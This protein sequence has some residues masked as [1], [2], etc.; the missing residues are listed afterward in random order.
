M[1]EAH[2]ISNNCLGCGKS[3]SRTALTELCYTFEVCPCNDYEYSG[4][5][6]GEAVWHKVC[7]LKIHGMEAKELES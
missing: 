4:K 2:R 6:L 7:F 3:I 1:N 5:H